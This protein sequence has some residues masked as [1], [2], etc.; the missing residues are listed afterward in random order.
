[1]SE[2]ERQSGEQ[3]D[4]EDAPVLPTVNPSAEKSS[5]PS[6]SSGGL[7]P[8]V[9]IATWI[10]LS[11][12]VIIFNKWIL[13]T[14][15][16]RFPIVLTTWHLAFATLM[17]QL[18]ARFTTVLDSRKKVPMTGKIYLRAIV[19][20]GLMFSL[21]LIC[22]NL[23]Y[24]YLSVSFIQMLK[25][26]TPVAVL[27][28]S[29]VFGVAPVNLKTLGNVSFI[30]IG[31]M[32]AS[33]GEI[34]FVLIGFLFQIGGIVF[35]ATRLVMVQ[36][37]LSS[38]EFKMD[39]L[40]SLYYFAPACAIMNGIVS[41]LVEIP[42]MT[43]ADVEKVGYFTFLVNAMIAFLLNVSVVFLI[44]KT[45]SLVMTLSGVLKDI[46]LV[47]ASMLIFRD[48]VAPLQFFGYS[49]ALGGLVYYKL[50][51]EK[52]REHMGG[53]QRSWAEYGV[54]H[55]AAR[56]IIVFIGVMVTLGL[57]LGGVSSSGALGDAYSAGAIAS[58]AGEKLG[59]WTGKGGAVGEQ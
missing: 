48:P 51:G 5:E 3:V 16:F 50:G 11:S 15:G 52:L 1:M 57:L 27:I 43:L 56:K 7:H 36:R 54:Q 41:L 17:T 32:I 37:L 44:G 14:A 13:D 23:T 8:A 6:S 29:W 46:L 40:V 24:L 28:A 31:V 2:K 34:N 20:I 30:V 10:S 39:P 33:Y 22:G 38:A 4:R 49:I 19:P 26:T 42:K 59:S 53:L 12:S 35:E 21:S 55:P 9:Y 45:S 18:L 58:H 25:A 47:L